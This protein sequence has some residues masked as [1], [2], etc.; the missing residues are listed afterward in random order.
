M[1]LIHR[2]AEISVS[3][4][5]QASADLLHGSSGNARH[6]LDLKHHTQFSSD[7][8]ILLSQ[9]LPSTVV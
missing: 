9:N 1:Y 3:K 4:A 7:V 5:A 8:N 2:N 6:I